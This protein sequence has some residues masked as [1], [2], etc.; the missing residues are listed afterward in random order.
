MKCAPPEEGGIAAGCRG[1][2]ARS[3][4]ESPFLTKGRLKSRRPRGG[5][6]GGPPD[7]ARMLLTRPPFWSLAH[8]L[9]PH[10]GH[11]G[12]GKAP[13]DQVHQD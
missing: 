5:L 4:T 2:D 12:V 8:K 6:R 11:H 1:F 3:L 13:P 9:G 7:A 10:T